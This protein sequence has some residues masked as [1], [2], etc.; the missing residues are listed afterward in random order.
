[1]RNDSLLD[2]PL[3]QLGQLVQLVPH[4]RLSNGKCTV[5]G[6]MVYK[7]GSIGMAPCPAVKV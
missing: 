4:G 6:T 3:V 1:M 2:N 7:C 5:S